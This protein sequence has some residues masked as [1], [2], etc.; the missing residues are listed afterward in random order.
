VRI[1]TLYLRARSAVAA[2]VQASTPAE[3]QQ[4]LTSAARDGARLGRER[5]KWALALAN[6]IA[7]SVASMRGERTAAVA[8]FA[9][10]EA[11]FRDLGM[12]LHA[13]VALRGRGQLLGGREGACL[14]H[15]ADTWMSEQTIRNPSRMAAM[16][17]PGVTAAD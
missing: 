9:A 6:L 17:A 2:A 3:R 16:L 8:S 12:R 15:E 10:G 1:E 4:L 5:A 13:T 7:A 14:V 11:A